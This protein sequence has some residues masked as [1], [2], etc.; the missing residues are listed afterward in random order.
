M[1]PV[2][3]ASKVHA[4]VFDFDG[5]ILDTESTLLNSWHTEFRRLGAELDI[6]QYLKVSFLGAPAGSG[7][8]LVGRQGQA[9]R[10]AWTC[11]TR[12]GGPS[13]ARP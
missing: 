9:R 13:R 3:P 4:I 7:H 8:P 5:V 12:R 1:T 6:D 2:P 11:G 10:V